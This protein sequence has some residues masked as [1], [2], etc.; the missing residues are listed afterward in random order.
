[1]AAQ[2]AEG[3]AELVV[4]GLELL[5]AA[6]LEPLAVGDVERELAGRVERRDLAR[7]GLGHVKVDLRGPGV[8]A[9]G[10]DGLGI[11]VAGQDPGAHPRARALGPRAGASGAP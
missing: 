1:M 10:L 4:E 3:R 6:G 11:A 9:G 8:R 7:V 2:P 5:A